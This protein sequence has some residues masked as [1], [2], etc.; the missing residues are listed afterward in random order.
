MGEGSIIL[1]LGAVA[2]ATIVPV[3]RFLRTNIFP[4]SVVFIDHDGK[5]LGEISPESI[6]Q[7]N[8]ADLERMHERVVKEKHLR[9]RAVA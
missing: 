1:L 6:H 3:V 2:L 9:I 7:A 4:R 5:E 8:L